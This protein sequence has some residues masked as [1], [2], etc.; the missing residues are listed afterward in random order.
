MTKM[1]LLGRLRDD[2]MFAAGAW[3]ALRHTTP[4]ARNPARVFPL[5]MA[6]LAQRY[7]DAPALISDAETLSYRGLA[8]RANRYARWA[9]A[10]GVRKGD[11]VCL[12]MPNRPEYMAIWLGLDAAG[13]V[14]ALHQHQSHRRLARL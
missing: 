12:M 5:L 2:A 14:V 7:G 6:E 3:R 13:A 1:N 4:I 11:V 8:A 9:R 10:Q